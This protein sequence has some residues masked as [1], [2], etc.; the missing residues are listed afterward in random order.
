MPVGKGDATI[1]DS[2]SATSSP[3]R[4]IA[5]FEYYAS[6]YFVYHRWNAGHSRHRE[7]PLKHFLDCRA[8][9]D[10]MLPCRKVKSVFTVQFCNGDRVTPIEASNPLFDQLPRLHQDVPFVGQYHRSTP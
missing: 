5:P 6:T 7:I 4:W 1:A 8:T 2:K 10:A 3:A 9:F